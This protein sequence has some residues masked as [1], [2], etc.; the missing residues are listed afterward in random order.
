MS[1]CGDN[2]L[3]LLPQVGLCILMLTLD[4]QIPAHVNIPV[5]VIWAT[6]ALAVVTTVV[7]AVAVGSLLLS[8][9]RVVCFA[10]DVANSDQLCLLAG[11]F[12]FLK[13]PRCWFGSSGC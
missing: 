4:F 11:F 5:G 2:F 7:G 8:T 1:W 6:M 13:N 10:K 9:I 3:A 12:R